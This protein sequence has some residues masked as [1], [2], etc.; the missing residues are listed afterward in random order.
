LLLIEMVSA[1]CAVVPVRPDGSAE[2]VP[3]DEFLRHG[4]RTLWIA[5][6]PDDE[7]FA[8][9]LLARSSIFYGNPLYFLVLTHGEG[10]ECGLSG[11]C[12]SDLGA[13]R[14]QELKQ[15]AAY[16]RAQLQ[17][18]RFFNAPL[19]VSSFPKRHELLSIWNRQGDPL[20]IVVAAIRRFRPD[21]VLTF[22]PDR[23]A[24]GHPE[25]QLAS[26]LATAAIRRAADRHMT[27]GN[28]RPHR[29]GRVYYVL[30][31]YWLLRVAGQGD[32][33]PVT[34]EWDA[35]HRCAPDA[36]CLEFMLRGTG[37]H[38]SQIPDMRMVQRYRSAF[39]TIRLRQVDPFQES[40][41]PGEP[42]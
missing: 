9:A 37:Y 13:L 28:L 27:V 42:R 36:T 16:Y 14:G 22:D 23:G 18:E 1:G 4:A 39:Q 2:K 25:H 41:D 30:H 20:G 24:T 33:G 5:A 8:G 29:V 10:G 11:G 21:L 3:L 26:R 12:G 34:E 6:H 19:P 31:R 40:K 38:R 7:L 17:H 35:R 15:A 32:P